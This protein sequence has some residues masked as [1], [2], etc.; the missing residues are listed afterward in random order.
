MAKQFSALTKT[1]TYRV[2]LAPKEQGSFY[3]RKA[4]DFYIGV[5]SF[6]AGEFD[7]TFVRMLSVDDFMWEADLPDTPFTTKEI[8]QMAKEYLEQLPSGKATEENFRAFFKKKGFTQFAGGLPC[9][10]ISDVDR[11]EEEPKGKNQAG[12]IGKAKLADLEALVT[13]KTK[14]AALEVLV[15]YLEQSHEYDKFLAYCKPLLLT[16]KALDEQ[17][18][19]PGVD[20]PHEW[21]FN[22]GKNGN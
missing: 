13:W 4:A 14:L 7:H 21:P 20:V 16:W 19:V 15:H 3:N 18:R 22:G 17:K 10:E 2:F 8:W 5:E 12:K 1:P 11:R 9:E 6:E